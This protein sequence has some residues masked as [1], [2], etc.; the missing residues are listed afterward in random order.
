MSNNAPITK[1]DDLRE[2]VFSLS[3]EALI[4]SV[5]NKEDFV[6]IN[7]KIEPTRNLMLKLATVTKTHSMDTTLVNVTI[8]GQDTI[9]VFKAVVVIGNKTASGH[10][11]CSTA[12]VT[13]KRKGD[14]RVEHDAMATAETRALKRAFE[15]AV[16][17]PFI[18][19][20]ILK[21][22]GG[23]EKKGEKKDTPSISPSEF[24]EK[25]KNA[26]ALTH[27]KNIWN[28]YSKNLLLYTK[29]EREELVKLKEEMKRILKERGC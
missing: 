1:L 26:K 12:E 17:L 16:G 4:N 21:L 9:Y 11:A 24:K 14:S 6:I 5:I 27:L 29:E 10:G 15:E 28:K 7:G 22:F 3:P 25:M 20:I 23:Y 8:K 18:N 2:R 19:E 13:T